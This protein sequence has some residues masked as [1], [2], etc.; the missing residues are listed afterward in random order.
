[1]LIPTRTKHALSGARL[2]YR[3]M[4]DA[5][6]TPAGL[7]LLP[8]NPAR[9]VAHA[10]KGSVPTSVAAKYEP[11]PAAAV[12]HPPGKTEQRVG[13]LAGPRRRETART[14]HVQPNARHT[15]INQMTLR[16]IAATAAQKAAMA[17]LRACKVN[18][19]S[20]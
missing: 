6:L 10:K 2:S 11:A 4:V 12:A 7:D 16:R 3:I 14:G 1:M 15:G 5:R 8:R 9:L 17:L 13:L 18:I 20:R 19:L